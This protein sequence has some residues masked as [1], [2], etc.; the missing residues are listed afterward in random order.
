MCRWNSKYECLKRPVESLH[1]WLE[2]KSPREVLP[3]PQKKGS[4]EK[5]K[6]CMEVWKIGEEKSQG[7]G[8]VGIFNRAQDVP[9]QYRVGQRGYKLVKVGKY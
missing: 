1:C 6:R 2:R 3:C 5:G 7:C 9:G 8:S 4:G